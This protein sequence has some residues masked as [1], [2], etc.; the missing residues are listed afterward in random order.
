MP[1]YDDYDDLDYYDDYGGDFDDGLDDD[2]DD[3]LIDDLDDQIDD[4]QDEIEDA[5]DS[6]RDEPVYSYQPP[7]KKPS[8]FT[9]ALTAAAIYHFLKKLF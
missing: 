7:Q 1:M 2:Q 8:F 9:R 4:L 6:Y 3:I 5:A